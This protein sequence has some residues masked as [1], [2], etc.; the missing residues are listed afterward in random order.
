[1]KNIFRSPTTRKLDAVLT[2]LVAARYDIQAL[3]G[4]VR[5]IMA[6]LADIQGK[7]TALQTSVANETTVDQ[8]VLALVSGLSSTISDL[9]QQLATAIANNDPAALQAV[10]DGLDQVKT[11]IDANANA[12]ASAVTQNTPA[13]PPSA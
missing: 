12:L 2:G 1:M 13:A 8:A 7:M 11:S 3:E 10:S 4:Q 6:T 5:Q 9:Q